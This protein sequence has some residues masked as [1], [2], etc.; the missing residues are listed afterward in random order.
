MSFFERGTPLVMLWASYIIIGLFCA[1]IAQYSNFGNGGIFYF[2]DTFL[3]SKI[4]PKWFGYWTLALYAAVV[5]MFGYVYSQQSASSMGAMPEIVYPLAMT[6]VLG[7]YFVWGWWNSSPSAVTTWADGQA[8]TFST[9]EKQDSWTDFRVTINL[10]IGVLVGAIVGPKIQDKLFGG[11]GNSFSDRMARYR[12]PANGAL[13]G[14]VP[15]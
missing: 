14:E 6:M 4:S 8:I 7:L 15:S 2:G 3:K 12:A 13:P 5:A 10:L 1:A 9:T 11:D